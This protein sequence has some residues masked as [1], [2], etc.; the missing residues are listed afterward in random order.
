MNPNRIFHMLSAKS[1]S[2]PESSKD[3]KKVHLDGTPS[4][5][6]PTYMTNFPYARGIIP[7]LHITISACSSIFKQSKVRNIW[8]PLGA[9]NADGRQ[10]RI[11]SAHFCSPIPSMAILYLTEL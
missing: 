2:Y 3:Y 1:N 4:C 11:A 8:K 9:M 6:V 7:I 5:G 10:T